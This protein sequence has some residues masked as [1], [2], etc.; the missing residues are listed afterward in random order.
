[1][2]VAALLPSIRQGKKRH[3]EAAH[4]LKY[5][6]VEAVRVAVAKSAG[7]FAVSWRFLEDFGVY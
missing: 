3:L 5:N 2:G 6:L 1:L 7:F 4:C